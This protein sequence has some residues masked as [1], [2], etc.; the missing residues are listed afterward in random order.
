MDEELTQNIVM[1]EELSQNIVMDEE[2]IQNIG[3]DEELIQNV[4]MGEKSW[5]TLWWMSKLLPRMRWIYPYA[6]LRNETLHSSNRKLLEESIEKDDLQLLFIGSLSKNS[7]FVIHYEQEL[8]LLR[9]E[10][11]EMMSCAR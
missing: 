2:L 3:M 6:K 9:E 7:F 4:A 5:R 8:T 1:D 11:H 10:L